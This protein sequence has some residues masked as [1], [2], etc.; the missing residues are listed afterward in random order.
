MF[1][2]KGGSTTDGKKQSSTSLEQRRSNYGII[3][4]KKVSVKLKHKIYKTAIKPT[5]THG[6]ECWTMKNKDEML[7]N[8]TE[9]RMLRW[10]QVVSTREHK[11]IIIIII[12]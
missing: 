3:C 8:K 1:D 12:I 10:I 5:I 6:A 4:D 2:A 7:M 11:I 9:M